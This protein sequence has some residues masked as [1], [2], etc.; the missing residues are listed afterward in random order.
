MAERDDELD[1]SLPQ[2]DQPAE[3]QE[4][5]VV[6]ALNEFQEAQE[7]LADDVAETDSTIAEAPP[8]IPAAPEIGPVELPP[9]AP[10]SP[11][12]DVAALQDHARDLVGAS[13][14]LAAE[15]DE[16]EDAQPGW[17]GDILAEIDRLAKEGPAP[18]AAPPPKAGRPS[19]V[20]GVPVDR[21]DEQFPEWGG[22]DAAAEQE[23]ALRDATRAVLVAHQRHAETVV[24]MLLDHA[25]AINR[26]TERLERER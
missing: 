17:V 10:P 19:P 24:T 15:R 22:K 13:E 4:H 21:T 9:E 3:F 20:L 1:D 8:E 5:R 14:E 12:E 26:L 25:H 18:E 23:A 2:P 6:Q 16:R 11:T 7:A